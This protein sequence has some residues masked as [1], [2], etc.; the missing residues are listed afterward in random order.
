MASRRRRGFTLIELLVVISIIGVL[1]GLLLPAVQAARKVA[2]RMQCSS[3]LRNIG[4]ALNGVLNTKNA[5]PNAGTFRENPTT[6][7][8]S[9]SSASNINAC[10]GSGS[11]SFGSGAH[12]NITDPPDV[13][14]LY[15]WVVDCLPGLDQADMANGWN[16]NRAYFSS[17]PDGTTGNPANAVISG[18]SIGVLTCPDDLTTQA[19]QG[20]LSYVVN[21][22]FS[23]WVGNT[24]IG[25]TGTAQGGIDSL[26]GPNWSGGSGP[27]AAALNLDYGVK[28]GVMFL[29]T[30]T[31]KFPWDRRTSGSSITDGSS[32]T[33]LA[34]ENLL[35]GASQTSAFTGGVPTNWA[36]P[37]P[38]FSAF[39]ASDNIC[40]AGVCGTGLT[41]NVST[42]DDTA[43]NWLFANFKGAVSGQPSYEFINYG[44]NIPTE[45]AFP[46]PSSNHSGGINA[47]YCD[48]SVRFLAD[49]VNGVV[50]SKLITPSGSKLPPGYKQ[51]PLS[52]DDY[53][54]N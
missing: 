19:G 14:P 17:V 23:R 53:G 16:H 49:T 6:P 38:N 18:K 44:Q 11:A 29:G 13:G 28:T 21:L 42:G 5:Y 30:D 7:P 45:G 20:N 52:S 34:S 31:G 51:F 48:G 2:R 43:T 39:V 15:S 25:W 41:G 10:F 8:F 36:C 50:Y 54:A 22:G 3:N 4:L 1:I 9:P 40:P 24:Q 37:H 12:Q 35:A 47:L 27:Q 33:I 26:T 46:Y 32:Q